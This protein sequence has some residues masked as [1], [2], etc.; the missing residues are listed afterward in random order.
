MSAIKKLI[1]MSML[2]VPAAL[3]NIAQAQTVAYLHTDALG[4]P[5]AV[6]DVAG[7]VIE[8]SEY[9]PYGHLLNR[10]GGDGPGYTGHVWDSATG[11]TYMQQRYYDSML[12]LFLSA[13]PVVAYESGPEQMHRYRYAKSSPFRFVDPDGR[14]A[15][16]RI[17]A[18]CESRG[19]GF[20]PGLMRTTA[21]SSMDSGSTGR[22]SSHKP[23]TDSVSRE[24]IKDLHPQVRDATLHFFEDVER[25]TGQVL[26]VVQGLRTFEEQ[27]DL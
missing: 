10:P 24:R 16:S 9:S 15:A 25:S 8:T 3:G 5:I 2:L 27:D 7:N 19:M 13:D 1:S 23:L 17:Q 11:M 22:Y 6:T 18:I 26:R 4:T 12:G 14:C 20:G 21:R